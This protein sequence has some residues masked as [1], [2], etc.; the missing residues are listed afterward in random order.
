MCCMQMVRTDVHDDRSTDEW[1]RLCESAPLRGSISCVRIDVEWKD[2]GWGNQKG[3]VIVLAGTQS[4][5]VTTV[6]LC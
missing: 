4:T 2:Q 5:W 6:R 1:R 3:R